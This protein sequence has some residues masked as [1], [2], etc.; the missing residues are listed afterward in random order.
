MTAYH[1]TGLL[2]ASLFLLSLAG[3]ASQLTTI[4]RRA[5]LERSRGHASAVLSLNY[6]SVTFL[7]YLAFFAYGF[8][9]APFNH[10]LVWPRL[11]GSLLVW[12]IL[13]EIARD[14]ADRASLFVAGTASF[15]LVGGAVLLAMRGAIAADLRLGPQLLSVLATALISQ[16]LVHQIRAVRRAG[17]RGAVSRALHG[18]TLAKDASTA[19]FGSA[20]GL[21]Q[22][23]PLL[24]MG[25]ASAG[26]KAILLWRLG[27]AAP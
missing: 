22:G 8:S 25:G 26:L 9:I 11:L 14:R 19:A 7:A 3:L 13:L 21:E 27:R 17:R 24:L 1:A 16:S 15:L 4:R 20:M 10:Y 18:L 12:A 6:F 5:A 23:W 2:N